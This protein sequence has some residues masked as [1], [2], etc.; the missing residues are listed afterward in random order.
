M[1]G[2]TVDTFLNLAVGLAGAL[3]GGYCTLRGTKISHELATKKEADAER[4]RM[5]STLML[6]RTEINAAW[7]IFKDEIGDELLAQDDGTPHRTIF[8]IGESPFPLFNSAPQA[9]NL[10]PHELAQDIVRFYMRAK[11]LIAMI[12][13]NNRDY[14]QALQYARSQLASYLDRARQQNMEMPEDMQQRI[15]EGSVDFMVALLGMGSIA[16]G[17]R[18]LARELEPIVRRITTAVDNLLVPT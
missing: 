6:L 4:E 9:L 15:F 12:E 17:M 7:S 1:E 5:V 11:G 16:D 2:H 18:N 8:P 13:I 14:E 3:I 10:L